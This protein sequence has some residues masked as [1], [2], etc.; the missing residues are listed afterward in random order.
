M[1]NIIKDPVVTFTDGF[2]KYFD[3]IRITDKGVII[4]G[5]IHGEFESYGFIPKSSIKE[6]KVDN[7]KKIKK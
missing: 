3:T 7:R 6:I 5:F 4:G 2:K 1:N